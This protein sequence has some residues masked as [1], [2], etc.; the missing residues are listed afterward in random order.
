[1][2]RDGTVATLRRATAL[3]RDAVR[4]FF[5]ELSPGSRQRRFMAAAEPTDTFINELCDDTSPARALTLIAWRQVGDA[6]RP[7][8]IASYTATRNATAEVAFAV[9]DRFQGRGIGTAML[10]RLAAVAARNGFERFQAVTSVD[11]DAML[12]VFR[13][14][15]FE[16][17]S[18]SAQGVADVRLNLTASE[19]AATVIDTRQRLATVASLAP[20]LTPGS[21]AVVGVSRDQTALGRRIFDN[22]A[23]GQF[24]GRLYPINA[25]VHEMGAH[26]CLR[27]VA[28]LPEPVDLA[29]VAVPWAQVDAVVD[30]CAAKGVKA[31]VVIS[32]GYAETG[33]EGQRRQAALLEKTRGCGMRLVGPNCMGVL[34][35][36]PSVRLNA[37][38]ADA[39]PPHGRLALA[40][41]SGGLGLAILRLATERQIGLSTFV[42]LG[43]KA[44][45]SGNDLLQYGESDPDTSVILLYL[46]SFGN[47]R[48]FGQL[49]RR[50]GRSKPIVA[51][52]AGRTH[53]GSRA[54]GSHTAGLASSE[55][56]VAALFQQSGVIRADGIGEMFDIAVCLDLQPL[57]PGTRV[58]IV[59]NA[60]GPGILAADACEAAGLTVGELSDPIR[61]ALAR[62]VPAGASLT[63]PV[64]LVAS[65]GPEAFR[66]AIDALLA[67]T[68][69]DALVVIHTPIDTARAGEIETGIRDGV[70]AARAAGA[71][72]KPVLACLMAQSATRGPIDTGQELIPTYPFPENAA[73]ALA[74]VA[75]YATWRRTPPGLLWS[76]DEIHADEARALCRDVVAARGSSWLSVEELRRVL[77]A[78]GLPLAAGSVAHNDDEAAAIASIL[79]FPVVLKLSTP[80]ILHKTDANVVRLHL[81]SEN[82]V[83]AAWHDIARCAALVAGPAPASGL[84]M[85]VQPMFSGVETI[86]GLTDDVNFGPIVA[87]GLGGVSVE[88]VQD[89]VFR[90]APITDKDAE[91][92]L[93]GVRGASLLRGF[94]GRPPVDL[95]ALRDVLLRVSLIGQLV[96][97]IQELDLNPVIALPDGHGC[98]IVDAR[99]RVG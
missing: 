18:K 15:G 77:Y 3:D 46:E 62:L 22:L 82:A 33:D 42:S 45:V 5:H 94:R 64:D 36:H 47:P 91:D 37:S 20:I 26:R 97:E 71:T 32:A 43:N 98:R 80:E 2:L 74:K 70:A 69:V 61:A 16:M 7:I 86:V 96:P 4:R 24:R 56:A 19:G 84:G 88:V 27:S 28:D 66:R 75:A 65:A 31:L 92:M 53:A 60:G 14:S 35:T 9:D 38:F 50:I 73:R 49:A 55:A 79:G 34:N 63:N 57:P 21:A 89:V 78:F 87:F 95:Q 81:A 29:I 52:K 72:G 23:G 41:Q 85:L 99:A 39:L 54:A 67:D 58:A 25:R 76:F 51:V 40:S 83:R 44:D 93:S 1:V 30:E 48:R 68:E 12:E 90:M 6:I 59:T 13:D 11:N 17:R 8:A 10:E